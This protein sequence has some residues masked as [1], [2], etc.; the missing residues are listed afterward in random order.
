MGRK[1]GRIHLWIN[2][3]P[4]IY[5]H[6][7]LLMTWMMLLM[8]RIM[9]ANLPFSTTSR[10]VNCECLDHNRIATNVRPNDQY[11]HPKRRVTQHFIP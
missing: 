5:A 10:V 1:L 9:F 4:I 7:P 11:R 3:Q 2:L 6:L 8:T